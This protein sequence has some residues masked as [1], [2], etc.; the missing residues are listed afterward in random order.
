MSSYKVENGD[1]K[2][3]LSELVSNLTDEE[4]DAV[5]DVIGWEHILE[6]FDRHI[7]GQSD[8]WTIGGAERGGYNIREHIEKVQGTKDERVKDLEAK[9]KH[10]EHEV[11]NYKQYYDWY[12]RWYHSPLVSES[13]KDYY[14]KTVGEPSKP[15]PE[16]AL[17]L[18]RS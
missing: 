14:L 3:D 8:F 10:L 11:N 18:E 13:N 16:T 4:V 12:W 2:I 6:R 1:I 15:K 17:E 5:A 7:T 9:I